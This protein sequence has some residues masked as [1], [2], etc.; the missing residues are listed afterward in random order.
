MDVHDKFAKMIEEPGT[1]KC[2]N[3]SGPMQHRGSG[4]YVC[5]NCGEEY[6]SDFG[7]IKKYLDENGPSDAFEIAQETGVSRKVIGE[8]LREGRMQVTI[9]PG[10][11][12]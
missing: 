8:L 11:Q 10:R 12:R 7:K 6:L 5:Q 1:V 3:C 2:S 4:V 9:A